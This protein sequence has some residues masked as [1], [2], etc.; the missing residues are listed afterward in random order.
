[1]ESIQ[2]IMLAASR[3]EPIGKSDEVLLIDR[4]QDCRDRLLDD[5]VL[6]AQNGERPWDPSTLEMYVLLAGRAR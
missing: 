3:P 6:Q 2:R 4:F 5:L 1:M